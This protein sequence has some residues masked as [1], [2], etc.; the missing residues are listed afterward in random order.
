MSE[1]S[2]TRYYLDIDLATKKIIEWNFGPKDQ[3]AVNLV[4][5]SMHRIFLTKGQYH[6]L[7][8]KIE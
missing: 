4:G 1:D 7:I 6:K 8:S 3:L 5:K 2:D